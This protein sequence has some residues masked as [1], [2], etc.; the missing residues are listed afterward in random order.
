[1]FHFIILTLSNFAALSQVVKSIFNEL[2]QVFNLYPGDYSQY[3]ELSE[4][5]LL[6]WLSAI[7]EHNTHIFLILFA[8]ILASTL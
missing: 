3:L 5:W 7:F 2:F 4:L 8:A 1:M 6:E